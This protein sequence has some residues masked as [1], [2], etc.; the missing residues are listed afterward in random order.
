MTTER[1]LLLNFNIIQIFIKLLW[2]SKVKDKENVS[3]MIYE[4]ITGDD[5]PIEKYNINALSQYM[6]V[7]FKAEINYF[8][9]SLNKFEP[10]M[11]KIK[12][13]YLMMQICSFSR[14]KNN[15][16]IGDMINFNISSNAIKVVN[17][18]LLRYYKKENEK[19][20]KIKLID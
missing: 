10:L 20:E 18:F 9:M 1:T 3:N 16:D 19:K 13:E 12:F 2:N 4:M 11:E 17:L 5:L 6:N 14:R 7:N 8:N 15:I